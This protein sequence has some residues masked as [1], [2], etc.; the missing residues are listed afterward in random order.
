MEIKDIM[1]TSPNAVKAGSYITN[2]VS[3]EMI[4]NSI[5]ETQEIH[6]N[7]IVGSVLLRRL[8]ELVFNKM[9]GYEDDIDSAENAE[10]KT[11]LDEYVEP[12]MVAKTQ[13][14]ICTPIT[15]KIRNMGVVYNSDQNVNN[16]GK[17]NAY[18]AQRRFNV[19]ADQCAT[20]LSMYL[21]SH[22]SDFPELSENDCGCGVF[23]RPL[24]GRRFVSVPLN[25]GQ[26]RGNC[27]CD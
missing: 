27:C 9:K 7:E 16:N 18:T 12:Y 13:A 20:R 6:L 14:M 15:L 8:K 2:E 24:I 17:D 10:Y 19:L 11:L 25:L 26:K 23:T 21:C 1:L 4:G 3:D 22:K 5:R